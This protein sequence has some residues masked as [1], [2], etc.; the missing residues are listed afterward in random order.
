MDYKNFFKEY[1]DSIFNLLKE[2]DTESINASVELIQKVQKNNKKI[3][4]VGNGGSAS[5]ASHTSV[6]FA[7]V[8]RVPSS[9]FNNANLITCFSNDYGY[10]NW[11]TEAIKAYC[12]K[13]DL[14][15]LISSSGTSKN[16][17][18]AAKYCQNNNID[19]ITLSGFNKDNSLT[20]CGKV[21]FHVNSEEYN[22]IEMTHHIIL[23][24]LVDIFVNKI[25]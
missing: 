9:T 22:F 16:I 20:K 25:L 15:I 18:N 23:V 7:K 12:N 14:L 4:I 11:V 24:S 19:L 21:N 5:I 17:I 6:D 3:Y 10:E 2:V 8:A 13:D 1:T